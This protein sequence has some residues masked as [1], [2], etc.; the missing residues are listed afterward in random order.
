M[1]A[2]AHG[3]Q[4]SLR[5]ANER[6]V[7]RAVQE[8][9]AL[10]QAE[11]ARLTGLSP[12]SVSN[13]VRQLSDARLLTLG[14][15]SSRGRRARS[16]RL[17][18]A[19]GVAVG[20][21]FG[22]SHLRVAVGNLC[23]EV[24]AERQVPLDLDASAQDGFAAAVRLLRRALGDVGVRRQDVVALALGVP[25]PID[26]TT[27]AMGS[28]SIL[29]GWAGVRVA[30]AFGEHVGMP[31]LVDNDAN[32]GA[33]GEFTCGAA[34][35]RQN[36]AYIKMSTGVGA[37]LVI[38]GRIYHGVGGTAGEIG[39]MTIDERGRVCRG[40]NRGCLETYAAAPF[41]LELLRHWHGPGLTTQ[42]QLELAA[43]GDVGCQRV[44]ADAGR[45]VGVA[46]A[47]LCN[48]L[49]PDTVVVGGP[50]AAAGDL[51]LDPIRDTVRRHAIASA[52]DQVMIVASEL[53]P[54]AEVL[55]ALAMA[56]AAAEPL[57]RLARRAI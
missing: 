27:G 13:I 23:Q 33:L 40:G 16:V 12:A 21:D 1:N 30:E 5:A 37:G 46:V 39:H 28:S 31:V 20:V 17:S 38:G 48:L 22:H 9:G 32:L 43:A 24:L 35:G 7:L 52:A 19:A 15:G 49:N 34:R 44:I 53:G 3:S 57:D 55:G 29:P 4:A 8:A 42:R 26:A 50:F 45:H 47:N 14:W 51:L 11:I 56:V 2:P 41:L 25:G 18:Q 36:I 6:R 10:S 54:R